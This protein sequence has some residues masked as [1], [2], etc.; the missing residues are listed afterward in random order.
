MT[1]PTPEPVI[2]AICGE[3]LGRRFD[4]RKD[5]DIAKEIG[6][7]LEL[8]D[9]VCARLSGIKNAEAISGAAR[10][11]RT[12]LEETIPGGF[13]EELEWLARLEKI[14]GPAPNSE[15]LKWLDAEFARILIKDCSTLRPTIHP[16]GPLRTIAGLLHWYRTGKEDRDLERACKAVLKAANPKG[17]RA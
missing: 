15:P 10:R 16:K 17:L 13:E 11:L 9:E 7:R 1:R 3:L 2:E 6:R 4:A 12:L 8:F 5:V 14:E